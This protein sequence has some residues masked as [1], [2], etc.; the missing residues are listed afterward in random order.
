MFYEQRVPEPER[1]RK[2]RRRPVRLWRP[3]EL[4]GLSVKRSDTY[5]TIDDRNPGEV[6]AEV[7]TILTSVAVPWPHL[8]EAGRLTFR[9]PR[10]ATPS[11]P[12]ILYLEETAFRA[13]V[14]ASRKRHQQLARGI[15]VGD[16]FWVRGS[17][18]Q[19]S[20]WTD[21][22]DVSAAARQTAK[23]ALYGAV[24]PKVAGKKLDRSISVTIIDPSPSLRPVRSP[25]RRCDHDRS[26]PTQG[27]LLRGRPCVRRQPGT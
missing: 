14:D 12:S 27:Q 24:T 23:I 22:V 5:L 15:R 20:A 8:D 4:K 26:C 2:R 7:I 25:A 6:G 21:I 13:Q 19:S 10:S 11:E 1:E 9:S 18:P 3:V 16:A 17:S